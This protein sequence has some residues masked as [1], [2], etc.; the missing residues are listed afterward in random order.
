MTIT[1]NPAA[2]ASAGPNQTVPAS[3]ATVTLAGSVGGGATGGYWSGGAGN[4]NPNTN[5]LNAVYTPTAGEKSARQILLTLTSTGQTAPCG[6]ATGSMT[7]TFNSSPVASDLTMG[8]VSG[9]PATLKIIG[10]KHA[11]TDADNDPLTVSAVQNPSAQGGGVTTDGTNVTYTSG[12]TF[13][14]AD[15]FSY[16]VS[17]NWGGATT[18]TVTVSVGPDG[19]GYNKVSGPTPIG[20]G[21]YQITYRGIPNYFYALEQATNLAAPVYWAP[22]LTNQA[23][24]TGLLIFSFAPSGGAGFYHTRFVPDP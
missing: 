5:T 18:N 19:E 24:S 9:L 22:V 11:P 14:G 20:G 12:I 23:S 8:A 2:T 16:T 13:T 21:M 1:I 10:G 3:S 17:D 7:I 15:T 4:F 6:S